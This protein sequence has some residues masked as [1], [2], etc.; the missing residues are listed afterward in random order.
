MPQLGGIQVSRPK[1]ISP[2]FRHIAD[3]SHRWGS[4]HPI[5]T[6]IIEALGRHERLRRVWILTSCCGTK[7]QFEA[8]ESLSGSSKISAITISVDWTKWSS[9]LPSLSTQEIAERFQIDRALGFKKLITSLPKLQSLELYIDIPFF[10][11]HQQA[12]LSK[13]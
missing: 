4:R 13:F 7:D 8:L 2:T 11:F 1:S 6:H 12:L 5:P 10:D 3:C 9:I